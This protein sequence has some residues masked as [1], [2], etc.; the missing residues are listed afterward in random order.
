MPSA[1]KPIVIYCASGARS[2]LAGQVLKKMGYLNVRSMAGGI[3]QWRNLGYPTLK[4][5]QMNPEQIVS[6]LTNS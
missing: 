6:R 5:E 1:E 4:E 3:R 2:L